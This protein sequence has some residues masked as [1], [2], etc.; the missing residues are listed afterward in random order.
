[1]LLSYTFSMV[2]RPCHVA[3]H[4]FSRLFLVRALVRATRIRRPDARRAVRLSATPPPLHR[5]LPL[6]LLGA[7]QAMPI[8]PRH[9]FIWFVRNDLRLHDNPV[10]AQIAR[11]KGSAEVLPVYIFDPRHFGTTRRDSPKTGSFR[12][13]FLLESVNDLRASL[14]SIG[15]DLVCCPHSSH[16]PNAGLCALLL[17]VNAFDSP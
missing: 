17:R 13:K 12:S 1:M 14:R 15:S 4:A 6:L 11:H 2:Q 3:V 10:L 5:A 9:R 16:P 7:A 8:A